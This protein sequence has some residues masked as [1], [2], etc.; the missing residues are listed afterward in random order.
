MT[1]LSIKPFASYY[2][3]MSKAVTLYAIV[4]HSASR[5]LL[6]QGHRVIAIATAVIS[7]RPAQRHSL[8]GRTGFILQPIRHSIAA[9]KQLVWFAVSANQAE[10]AGDPGYQ[11]PFSV[12]TLALAGVGSFTLPYP[13]RDYSSGL[14]MSALYHGLPVPLPP[15]FAIIFSE[16]ACHLAS[17]QS[18]ISLQPDQLINVNHMLQCG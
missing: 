8:K 13:N 16:P 1:A 11:P 17:K 12:M 7:P 6:P 4:N 10:S 5:C 3:G 18:L 2:P 15:S 14:K 9:V